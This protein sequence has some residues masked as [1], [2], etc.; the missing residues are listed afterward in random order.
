MYTARE[1]QRLSQLNKASSGIHISFDYDRLPREIEWAKF[2]DHF[3]SDGTSRI[4]FDP[5][6]QYVTFPRV[7]VKLTGRLADIERKNEKARPG[8]VS[9]KDMVN[10]FEWLYKKDVRHIIK[11][12]VEEYENL[13]DKAHSDQAIQKCLESLIIDH[14]DWQKTDLDPETILHVSSKAPTT[15]DDLKDTELL[16]N[17]RL[18]ELSLRWSGSNAV[19]RAWSEPEGLPMLPHLQTIHLFKPPLDQVCDTRRGFLFVA[20]K[21]I[22]QDT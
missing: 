16:P 12:S 1:A 4:Q 10:F 8:P 7:E 20:C 19:L 18:R 2:T 13:D 3:G 21:L 14:L 5:V 6:L 11:V 17:R 22:E 9:R 15:G